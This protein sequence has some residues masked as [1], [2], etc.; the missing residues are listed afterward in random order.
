MKLIILFL[1]LISQIFAANLLTYNLYDRS[2]RIDIMLSFDS[3][4]DGQI[5]QEKKKNSITLK[6]NNLS[7]NKLVKK[8][9]DSKI[10]QKLTIKPDKNSLMIIIESKNQI[11]I[12]ASKTTDGF[13]LRIRI[14]SIDKPKKKST[15]T[16]FLSQNSKKTV[17]GNEKLLDTRYITVVAIL[18]FMLIIMFWIRK[19]YSVKNFSSNKKSWLFKKSEGDFD[20]IKVVYKKQVDIKNSV[21]LLEFKN[22]RYLVM[23]GN[24]NLLLD[25]FGQSELQDTSEFEKAFE[26]NRKKL[27]EYLK[28][29][30]QKLENYK[31]KA[32]SDFHKDFEFY[33]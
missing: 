18:F 26:D 12:I 4:Y 14:K 8:S 5:F 17:Y 28:L 23:S 9:I 25:T 21:I 24:S 3:P 19:K 20:D 11:G 2:D 30:D 33:K 7:F 27:D 6:L 29:Q 13:G 10:A 22:K 1:A 31:E 32:S 15:A 16:T